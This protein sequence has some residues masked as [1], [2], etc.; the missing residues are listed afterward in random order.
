MEAKLTRLAQVLADAAPGVVA[1]SGG[2]DSRFL[3]FFAWAHHLDYTAVFLDGP[4]MTPAERSWALDWLKRNAP[5]FRT[6]PLDL[7]TLP[8]VRT[9]SADRCY[10]CKHLGFEQ[11][12]ALAKQLGRPQVFDGGTGSDAGEYRPGT[13][14]LR[15]LGVRSPLA[16]CGIT[17]AEIRLAGGRMGLD[18]PDQPSR[19]C[20]L[21]RF[22]YGLQAD[23]LTLQRLGRVEDTLFDLGLRRFRLRIISDGRAVLHV[24]QEEAG[25]LEQERNA[26]RDVLRRENFADASIETVAELSGFFDRTRKK[27]AS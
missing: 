21:T 2:V 19:P 11:I 24:S 4:H 12:V 26:V 6:I 14:A 8:Q 20:L 1:V 15:E 10:H 27:N 3:S 7:L 13:R 17:K 22:N 18:W 9:T 16:A 23:A 25:L 5:E